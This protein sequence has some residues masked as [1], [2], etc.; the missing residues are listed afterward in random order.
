MPSMKSA[1]I[2]ALLGIATVAGVGNLE[3]HKGATGI[4]M[5]RMMSMKSMGDGMKELAAMVTGKAPYDAAK[6]KTIATTI[7]EDAEGIPK[8]FPK[9]SIKGPSEALPSIWKDWDGFKG[10][11]DNLAMLSDKMIGSANDGKAVALGLFAQMG[12]TCSGCHQDYR[13]KKK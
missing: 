2:L 3:A 5:Q 7:K 13:K 11:A 9:D 1:T 8:Q 4:V 6:A 12:K 10:H